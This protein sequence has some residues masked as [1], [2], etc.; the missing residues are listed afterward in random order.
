MY[1]PVV[2]PRRRANVHPRHRNHPHLVYQ[3]GVNNGEFNDCPFLSVAQDLRL[4]LSIVVQQEERIRYAGHTVI[5]C[6]ADETVWIQ[7]Q[8]LGRQL[9]AKYEPLVF[10]RETGPEMALWTV[11]SVAQSSLPR[12]LS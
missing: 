7:S 11:V 8:G 3:Y 1:N 12:N 9:N 4:N 6:K 10:L 2:E 5:R